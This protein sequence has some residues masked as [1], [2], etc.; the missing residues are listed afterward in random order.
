MLESGFVEDKD[1][2]EGCEEEVKDD[3]EEPADVTVS[4]LKS[5][6]AGVPAYQTTR[7]S[8]MNWRS[9]RSLGHALIQAYSEGGNWKY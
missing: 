6:T 2:G 8:S 9:V 7:N 5:G 3:A 1:V 4:A